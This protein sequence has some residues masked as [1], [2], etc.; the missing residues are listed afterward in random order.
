[1]NDAKQGR[2]R[3]GRS[4]FRRGIALAPLAALGLCAIP[5]HADPGD[6]QAMPGLWKTVITPIRHGH[7]GKPSIEWHC[8]DEGADPWAAF[9]GFTAAGMEACE[10]SDQHRSSTALTWTLS[11][12]S[13]A[14][15]KGRVAFDSAEHYTAGIALPGGGDVVHVEGSRHAACTSPSD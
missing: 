3:P 14:P 12:P 8:V 1:M 2:R 10:R 9:A 4:I 6:F 5:S 7:P 13:H 15:A 11:C